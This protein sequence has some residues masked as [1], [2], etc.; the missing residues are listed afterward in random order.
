[1]ESLNESKKQPLSINVEYNLKGEHLYEFDGTIS[2]TPSVTV[3]LN[4]PSGMKQSDT[5]N[6][7][8]LF[9]KILADFTAMQD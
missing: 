7:R 9:E 8:K 5:D 6:I 1:M 4:F 2:G 3:K